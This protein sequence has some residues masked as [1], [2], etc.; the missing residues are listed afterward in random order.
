MV[1]SLCLVRPEIGEITE[2]GLRSLTA[3]KLLDI[4]IYL[5]R[6]FPSPLQDPS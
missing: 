1:M 3:I 5:L 4:M 2:L 6:Q